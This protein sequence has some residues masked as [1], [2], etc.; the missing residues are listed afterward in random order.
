MLANVSL[1]IQEESHKAVVCSL[2]SLTSRG[3]AFTKF[4]T[5]AFKPEI[6]SEE[7]ERKVVRLLTGG[8]NL[9]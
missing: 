3:R 1:M 6:H 7:G 4:S 9:T 5:A 8:I 2:I